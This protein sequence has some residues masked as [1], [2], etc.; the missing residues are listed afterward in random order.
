MEWGWGRKAEQRCFWDGTWG[1]RGKRNV[2]EV[3]AAHDEF[4]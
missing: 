1:G 3:D 2:K 4:I